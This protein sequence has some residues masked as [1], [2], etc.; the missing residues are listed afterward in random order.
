MI[1]RYSGFPT[2]DVSEHP[3]TTVMDYHWDTA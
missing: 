2:V 1:R 3:P